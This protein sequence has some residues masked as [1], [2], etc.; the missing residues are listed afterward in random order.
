MNTRRWRSLGAVSEASILRKRVNE[1][2]LIV[3]RHLTQIQICL[4]NLLDV[5]RQG[6]EEA[7]VISRYEYNLEGIRGNERL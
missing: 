3:H 6:V 5:S 7:G 2:R 4:W 1:G